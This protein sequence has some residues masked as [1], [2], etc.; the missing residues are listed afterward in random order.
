VPVALLNPGERKR[1][2]SVNSYRPF[3]GK[4]IEKHGREK[5]A[6]QTNGNQEIRSWGKGKTLGELNSETLKAYLGRKGSEGSTDCFYLRIRLG[7]GKRD[8]K[9]RK[10]M[11][12]KKKEGKADRRTSTSR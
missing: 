7:P 5:G 6:S 4:T 8:I 12:N 10:I 2:I 3:G 11:A 1:R 9:S